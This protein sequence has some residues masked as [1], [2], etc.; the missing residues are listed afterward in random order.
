MLYRKKP[1]VVQAERWFPQDAPNPPKEGEAP[2][3]RKPERLGVRFCPPV[4]ED[5]S[6]TRGIIFDR[7]ARYVFDTPD[8]PI[9]I[10]PGDWVVTFS[11]GFRYRERAADLAALYE[12]LIRTD[13]QVKSLRFWKRFR[14]WFR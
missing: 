5:L 12:P 3:A 2:K 6:R 13:T 10:A 4:R 14:E 8:G 9:D 1:I 7:P 11:S